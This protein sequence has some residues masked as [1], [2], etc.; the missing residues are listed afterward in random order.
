MTSLAPEAEKAL[1]HHVTQ[2]LAASHRYLAAAANLSETGLDGMAGWMMAQSEEERSH[3]MKFYHYIHERNG[4]VRLQEIPRP[5]ED[6][7]TAKE[8]FEEALRLEQATT[9]R[10]RALHRQAREGDDV[11]LEVFLQW[12][13]QEQ[14]QE[15]SQL[16]SILDRFRLAGSDHAALL[17]LDQEMARRATPQ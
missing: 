13:I 16:N 2:E 5:P 10:I 4:S 8:I 6:P 11:A 14:V 9:Q 12:F 3:A 17:L 7:T 1:N 15:E